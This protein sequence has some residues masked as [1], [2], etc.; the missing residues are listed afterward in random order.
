M[1]D[2]GGEI[3]IRQDEPSEQDAKL[4]PGEGDEGGSGIGWR[5]SGCDVASKS[6]ST[7]ESSPAR[8][9]NGQALTLPWSPGRGWG[10][11][12]HSVASDESEGV[13]GSQGPTFSATERQVLPK[14]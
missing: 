4:T 14:G 13:G 10:L 2:K 1:G 12:G 5:S 3:R 8:A 7:Q 6:C 11:P 9:R